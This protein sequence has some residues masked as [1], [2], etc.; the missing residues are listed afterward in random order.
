MGTTFRGRQHF[1]CLLLLFAVFAIIGCSSGAGPGAVTAVSISPAAASV[2]LNAQ[3]TFTATVTLSGGTSSSNASTSTT[4]TWLVNGVAGGNATTGTI[5]TSTTDPHEGI[6]TAPSLVPA[7][8]N[9]QVNITATTPKSATATASEGT[10]TSNTAVV[11]ISPGLGLA[12]V[13]PPAT[14]PAGDS[15]QFHAT[16]NGVADPNATWTVSSTTGGAIGSID[17][18]SGVYTAPNFPPPGAIVTVTATDSSGSTSVSVTTT[19]QV[20]YSDATLHGSFAFSYT[21]NDSQGFLAAA[22][23]V[24]ADGQGH[25]S[26]V[27]DVSSFLSGIATAAQIFP[28]SSYV[29]GPD[30]RGTAI[31]CLTQDC[32][33]RQTL[34]F[35]LTTNQ[36]AIVTRFDSG[37]TGSGSMDQQT[38]SISSPTLGLINGPYVF[39]AIGTSGSSSSFVPEGLAGAF[40][41]NG[42]GTISNTPATILDVHVG[43][44]TA[45]TQD[46]SLGGTY[47]FDST[48]T[49]TGR[50]TLTLTSTATG[51]L[52]FAFY[53]V[54]STH[55]NIVE[56]DRNA[57]LAGSIFTAATGPFSAA[58][59]AAGNY[60]LV[61]GGSSSAGPYAAGAVLASDGNGNVSGGTLDSNKAGTVSSSLAVNP[62]SYTIDP[63]TGRI[64]LKVFTGSGA[65][66]AAPATGLSEFAGY[67]TAQNG[68]LLLQI[69]S[70]ALSTGIALQQTSASALAS[71]G[72][73]L[74][75]AS[76]GLFHG[77]NSSAQ[78]ISGQFSTASGFAGNLDINFTHAF[79]SDPINTT[80]SSLGS[81]AAN[82]RGTLTLTATSPAV[83]YK[84]VYYMANANEALLFDQDTGTVAIGSVQR[85]F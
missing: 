36:H 71:G 5:V 3:A 16:L 44:S 18:H 78:N 7:A 30:G 37:P 34:A 20:T 70:S 53:L 21:G 63:N 61:A 14:V 33:D 26:G 51:T 47:S 39:S 35:V 49:G 65:C 15:T 19:L 84:L 12:I 81:P 80:T 76:Q 50:G 64:D 10:I 62:C 23:S 58:N 8:N 69:D 60:V 77:G 54:D 43:A 59:L 75:L 57:F 6:Y 52:Q 56:M 41:S 28:S 29:V 82:G 38:L 66:P 67:Q 85:Q 46:T 4:I 11:T 9:G 68:I 45:A 74:T 25:L 27:E 79:Q 72:F 55:L 73:A 22:G 32:Q 83:T 1:I 48:N 13:A 2:S 31:L 24:F 40:S 42:N 17:L